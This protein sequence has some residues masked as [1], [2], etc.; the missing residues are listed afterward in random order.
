MTPA[1]CKTISPLVHVRAW[2][3]VCALSLTG[4]SGCITTPDAR[5]LASSQFAELNN[6]PPTWITQPPR[7]Q[8]WL[9]GTG[10]ADVYGN[11]AQAIKRAEQQARLDI[12]SQL[13]VTIGGKI[14]ADTHSQNNSGQESV[15]TFASQWVQ[16]R[17][18]AIT[19]D[20]VRIRD[21]FSNAK[22]A[23][24]LAELNRAQ[25][26]Q[27]LRTRINKLDADIT[28]LSAQTFST[29]PLA[30]VRQRS[31]FLQQF[32]QRKQWASQLNLLTPSQPAPKLSPA[33]KA[34]RKAIVNDIAN[35]HVRL[36]TS[37]DATRIKPN[38]AK[39]LT[40]MGLTLKDNTEKHDVIVA[41]NRRDKVVTKGAQ[42]YLFA[43]H[44]LLI[45]NA[46]N[47]TLKSY[48][49]TQKTASGSLDLATQTSAD[50]TADWV[51]AQLAEFFYPP[52]AQ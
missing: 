3:F 17:I 41:L 19:L 49:H 31:P 40:S 20:G 18:P 45:K 33:L 14:N 7:R 23:Y 29:Q 43:S 4:L 30:R 5:Q 44:T 27:N 25:A 13:R 10:T 42:T 15:Q 9:V 38:L 39:S 51:K 12:A 26:S 47:T 34:L 28:Q 24:A 2:M 36:E 22:F 48:T 35:L 21:T 11:Q 8:G 1:P 16:Q 52:P 37:E 6:Q 32:E 50:K 46:Q